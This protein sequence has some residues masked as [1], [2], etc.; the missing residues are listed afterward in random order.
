MYCFP[1]I[2]LPSKAIAEAKK[3]NVQP[4]LFYCMQL[5]DNTGIC[6]VPGSGFGQADGTFHF[7]T[8][9]LPLESQLDP[10]LEKMAVFHKQFMSKYKN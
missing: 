8:T 4:D 5:L 6:V 7:R 2:R 1:Q 10:V 3:Q 9:F